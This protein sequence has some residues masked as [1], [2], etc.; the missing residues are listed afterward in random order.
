MDSTIWSDLTI[1]AYGL[2]IFVLVCII[3]IM[4]MLFAVRFVGR[5]AR[6]TI[7]VLKKK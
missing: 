3:P 2:A 4:I 6:K 1:N 5:S 7:A